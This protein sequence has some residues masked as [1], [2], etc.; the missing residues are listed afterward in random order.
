VILIL[1]VALILLQYEPFRRFGTAIL[2]SAGIVG[3]V[4][5]IAAQRTLSDLI[6]G[7]QIAITQPIRV[8]DVVIVEGE[9]G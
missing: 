7:I 1:A 3:I 6:A 2:A 9:F 4:V 8:D 5:G